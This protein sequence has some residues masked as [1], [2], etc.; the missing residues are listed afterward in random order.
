MTNNTNE[1]GS[2]NNPYQMAL[3]QLEETA[4]IINLDEGIHKILAKPKRVLTV[5][6]PVKMDD[7]RIEVFTGFRSQHNDAR[8]PFKGGIRYHPQVTIE[9][10]MALSMWMTWKCA[11]VGIPL[12]GGKG[13]IICNPKKMSTSELE[14][15]TRRYAYA[16]SDI[17]GPYTDIPAPDVYTGGQEMS[18]IMDTYSTLKGNRGEPGLIT[19][20][21]LPIG[22]SLGRTEATGRGLSFTVREAAK[23]QNINMNE[24]V[25]VVQGFGNAGQYAAQLVEEQGAKIIA[26][27]DTQ[28]AII[29]KNGFKANELIKYKL[30]KKSIRGFP[31][32][33][34]IN[35]DELLTT[36]CTILIPAALENQITKENASRIKTK[37]VAEAANGP[38][39]PEA[40]K[41]LYENNILV[42]PDVLAN[43]GG[44]TVSYF[45][46]LQNLRREYWSEDEVNNRL[47]VIMTKAFGEVYDAHQKYNTNM[48]TASIALA[49][50]RVAEA[51]KLRGIWP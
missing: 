39:T 6:L 21:P 34:E 50:N 49:V 4:K 44:V 19:G 30:E 11:V 7:G 10:V 9:E 16:I 23:K 35:N 41:I 33:T 31:G 45:E 47:D 46:W 17:I 26:V 27:S 36:E 37:I 20:K 51:I 28:G 18:W 40:D 22:G 1:L 8:G 25:V 12:G 24:A 14:R 13:G 32:A 48:R 3:K 2:T 42:I 38:T 15:M 29:N 43:S 5:S